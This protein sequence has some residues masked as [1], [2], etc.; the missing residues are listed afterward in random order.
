VELTRKALEKLGSYGAGVFRSGRGCRVSPA[1]DAMSQVAR[2]KEKLILYSYEGNQFCRLVREV[3]MELDITYELR[4]AGKGSSRRTELA[5]LSGGSTQCPYLVDPNTGK[6]MPESADIIAYLYKE[7]ALWTPPPELL[8]WASEVVLAAAR[9]IFE[10]LTPIQAG[11]RYLGEV[12]I[13][14]L[15]LG[16]PLRLKQRRQIQKLR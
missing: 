12:H 3:L 9:P 10:V 1:A 15:S 4:S 16:L 11:S 7:Y 13:R 2:P 8:E 5:E 6:A 14:H